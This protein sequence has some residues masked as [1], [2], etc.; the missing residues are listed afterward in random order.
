MKLLSA[1]P[2]SFGTAKM[3]S[4]G[5]DL[6]KIWVWAGFRI[7]LCGKVSLVYHSNNDL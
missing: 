3:V 2:F 4:S 5:N 7:L 1:N 6:I